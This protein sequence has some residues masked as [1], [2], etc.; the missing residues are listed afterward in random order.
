[1][2]ALSAFT[3]AADFYLTP[4]GVGKKDGS[5]WDHALG[6]TALDQVVN[7]RMKPGDRLLLGGGEYPGAALNITTGGADGRPKTIEGVDRG[8]GLPVFSGHWNVEAPTKGGTALR[9]APGASHVVV[10]K[11]RLRG[12]VFC[13]QA[14]V[15]KDGAPRTHWMFDDVDMEQFRHGFY[16][17]DCDDWKLSGCDL[18]RYS[19]HAFRFDQGCDRVTLQRCVAD[20]SEGDAEWEKHT[21]LFPFGFCVTDGGAP[22]TAFLFED[23]LARNNMMPLQKTK[24]KNGDG[25]VIESNTTDVTLVRCRAIRN[26]DGGFDLKVPDVKLTDCVAIGNSRSFRVWHTGTLTNCFAGWAGTGLWTN[27]GP[28]TA[29]RCTFHSVNIGVATDDRATQPLTVNDSLISL[30]TD[31]AVPTLNTAKGKNMLNGTIIT[32]PS[33]AEKDPAYLRPDPSWDGL[34]DAMNSRAY[35]DKGYRAAAAK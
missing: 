24:Y 12:Y 16:L 6:Q 26:Q 19:K 21:E 31:T 35:P 1:M 29:T 9:I 15:A 13:V 10:R 25:F 3:S 34:G 22:N 20:C 11:L 23:C 14:P 33:R 7:E 5:S 27:G 17:A 18:K 28:I 32:G 2:V 4:T 30:S 8:S